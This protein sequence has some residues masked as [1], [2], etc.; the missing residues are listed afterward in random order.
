MPR[1]PSRKI[2]SSITRKN[3]SWLWR[4]AETESS[5]DQESNAFQDPETVLSEASKNQKTNQK[6]HMF[7]SD[8]EV[9]PFSIDYDDCQFTRKEYLESIKSFYLDVT[10]RPSIDVFANT[11]QSDKTGIGT[12][13]NTL[14][15]RKLSF[16]R[17]QFFAYIYEQVLRPE[18]SYGIK[19][20][21]STSVEKRFQILRRAIGERPFKESLEP[22]YLGEWNSYSDAHSPIPKPN[23]NELS[24]TS[25][26]STSDIDEYRESLFRKTSHRLTFSDLYENYLDSF[27]H[28]SLAQRH[29]EPEEF[30]VNLYEKSESKSES[31]LNY[32]VTNRASNLTPLTEKNNSNSLEL[33]RITELKILEFYTCQDRLMMLNKVKSYLKAGYRVKCKINFIHYP[34]R[35]ERILESIAKELKLISEVEKSSK[36]YSANYSSMTFIPLKLYFQ[37][38]N[39]KELPLKQN[40]K[41]KELPLKQKEKIQELPLQKNDSILLYQ[42]ADL[43]DNSQELIR[44]DVKNNSLKKN[45]KIY[46][47]YD[48]RNKISE[49]KNLEKKNFSFGFQEDDLNANLKDYKT[50]LFKDKTLC[51]TLVNKKI[52]NAILDIRKF[53][54][55]KLDLIFREEDF[56][57]L[58]DD[59]IGE[60]GLRVEKLKYKS[61]SKRL[62][63]FRWF[64]C[65]LNG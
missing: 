55:Y 56:S 45:N 52:E 26:W 2:P 8:V 12:A 1:S 58:P 9:E 31:N 62:K 23:H 48:Q 33:N 28:S 41:I 42:K 16:S 32:D 34:F 17:W 4:W 27:S 64:K 63:L 25:Q 15:G 7:M 51:S 43:R 65:K 38:K 59:M 10:D 47:K 36:I 5:N 18:S 6:S 50:D 44:H 29:L 19:L 30:F 49:E 22:V 60:L 37:N 35:S 14:L 13:I 53:N 57:F 21:N 3:S 24:K 54:R 46:N 40:E 61:N 20:L 11:N 39:I